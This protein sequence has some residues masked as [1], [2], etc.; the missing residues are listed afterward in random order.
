MDDTHP[1]F[2]VLEPVINFLRMNFFLNFAHEFLTLKRWNRGGQ[3]L[4]YFLI[5][6]KN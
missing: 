1:C 4:D 5:F 3:V 6:I 2:S